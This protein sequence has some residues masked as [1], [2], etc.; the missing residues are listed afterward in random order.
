[1][2]TETKEIYKCEH[3]KKLYQLK[4][5]CLLHETTCKKNK[6]NHRA[7]FGCNN[8]TKKT[9][10]IVYDTGYGESQRKVDLLYCTKL[11]IFLYPPKVEH[12]GNQYETHPKENKPMPKEC[13]T[14]EE[15]NF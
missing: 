1:M 11:D 4:K 15:L 9:E 2:I 13:S 10:T 12:K 14:F 5:Y 7:C 8:L 6:E 3:C